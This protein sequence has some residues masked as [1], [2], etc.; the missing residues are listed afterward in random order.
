VIRVEGLR[1]SFGDVRAV[2]G[3]DLQVERGELLVLLGQNGAGKSTTLR[4]LGGILRPDAG[5]IELDGL[6]LPEKLDAV[7]ARLGVVPDQARLY[8]RNT[9]PEYLD[10]FGYLYGVP[11]AERRTK[12]AALLERFELADRAD[13]VLAAY[14]RGMAQKVALIR[15]TL[16]DPD[17][18]FC[19]EPT[20]GLDPV[21]A[22]DM[23]H[24][25]AEQKD[26]GAALIVTTHVLSEAELMADRIAIMRKGVIVTRGTLEE[27][28]REA[29][30]G[31]RLTAHLSKTVAD[32]EPLNS[33]LG[34][35]AVEHALSGDRLTYTLPWTATVADRAAFAAELQRRLSS[36]EAPF[37]ELEEEQTSLESV[38][39]KAMDEPVS[40]SSVPMPAPAAVSGIG[41]P[42]M[43]A[44][45]RSQG[46]LLRNSLPFYV[47]SWW[48]RGDLSWVMYLN[49]FV[50][51]LVAGTSLFGQ[52]PGV[53]GQVAERFAGGTALQAGLLL[54]L[55]FMSFAL[56]ESIKSSIGIW[57]EKAQQSLEV[58]LYTPID[59]PSLI[60]LE[61]L[62]GAVVSTVWVTFW[63]AAGMT[64]LTLFGQSAPW[65]L[66]PIF[67]FVAAV[68]AY[69]AAMGRML[70]FMLFPREG[71]AG[72]A[73][74]FLLSPVSAAVADLP[75]ALFVFRSPLAPASLLLPI[76]ACF[77]LTVLC[78]TTFDRERLMETGLGRTRKRRVWL[79][80][81]LI[82]RNAAAIAAGLMLALAPAAIA[83]IVSSNAHWHSWSDVRSVGMSAE[84]NVAPF[85][86]TPVSNQVPDA[87]NVPATSGVTVAAAALAGIVA[88][89]AL[90]LALVIV[91]FAAFFLL[92]VPALLGLI[93]ASAAWG[94]QLGFGGATPLQPWLV[95]A[96]GI[97]LLALALNTGAAL[98]IYWSLVFGS[99]RRLDRLR[100]AWSGY[101]SLFRGL[102]LPACALFGIVV[103]RLL[104]AG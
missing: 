96:G 66:L 56:L 84:A 63:M 29:A 88:M 82:R 43:F 11:E 51:L 1:K 36:Q 95:G 28:R 54:P 15:A 68:T 104:A 20:A 53:A 3:V 48:R 74:S 71:A 72:G 102:V 60:W 50:L 97:A 87:S 78:G 61:V 16:H 91:S 86:A 57:W 32:P 89:L 103:F 13:T 58:L 45:L 8:G 34:Q 2:D 81:A 19:D 76:T 33:W 42:R 12:I 7:R 22:A 101:W 70:G 80:I 37:H 93:A 25:L 6:R 85:E 99:G 14:S 39:L 41:A 9:A 90:M 44:S 83:A 73:W 65:D 64:L 46:N 47:S 38:Y 77:A 49:A 10:R 24:Y 26:R 5:L 62:P 35:H 52:L 21:A 94:I 79:P 92:G 4:C 55:F 27:L 100:E 40:P 30:K 17:W 69:W 59:D 18:I 31:R 98:P 67:T 23:R 75:L